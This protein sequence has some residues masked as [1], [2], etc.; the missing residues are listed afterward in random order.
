MNKITGGSQWKNA[1]GKKHYELNRQEYLTAAIRRRRRNQLFILEYRKTQKCMDCGNPD[2]RVLDFDHLKNKR[3]A[4]G[5]LA[6]NGVAIETL[7]TEIAKCV[8]RCANCHRIKT[9]IERG[10]NASITIN[11]LVV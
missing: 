1:K 10:H 7:K 9:Y 8:V 5:R 4:I 6:Q 11:A 3:D 2:F